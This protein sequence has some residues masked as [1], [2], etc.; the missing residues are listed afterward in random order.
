MKLPNWIDKILRR[1][2]AKT[3]LPSMS[4]KETFLEYL[5]KPSVEIF[6]AVRQ[7]VSESD[8]YLPY[9]NELDVLAANLCAEDPQAAIEYFWQTFPSLLLSPSAHMM[10]SKAY[11]DLKKENEAEGEKAM[12]RL[13]LKSILATGKGTKKKPYA[14]MRI[15]DEW[16][17]LSALRKQAGPQFLMMGNNRVLDLLQCSDGSEV[18]FDITLMFGRGRKRD[19]SAVAE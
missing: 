12:G 18:Y 19:S 2:P 9:S 13:I 10:L 11:L 4:V 8:R 6:L 16:N 7:K 15:S 1:E 5:K 14:V 3:I 17:V